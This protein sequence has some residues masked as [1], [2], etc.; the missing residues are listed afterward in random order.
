[1]LYSHALEYRYQNILSCLEGKNCYFPIEIDTEYTHIANLIHP[2]VDY[3]TNIC[4]QCRGINHDKTSIYTYPEIAHISRHKALQTEFVGWDY[5]RDLGLEITPLVLRYEDLNEPVPWIQVD[6]YSFFAVAEFPRVFRGQYREDY[7]NILIHGVRNGGIDQGRRLRTYHREHGYYLNWIQTPWLVLIDNNIYSVRLSIY[8]T[9]ATHGVTN[10]KNFCSNSGIVLPYKDNFT[11]EEKSRMLEMYRDRPDEFDNYAKGDLFN[12]QALIKNADKFSDIYKSLGLERYFTDPKLTIGATVSR[13][14]EAGIYK[15]FDSP[16]VNKNIIN[17]FCKYSSADYI[18]RLSTTGAL[19]A[20][21]DGGRCRNNRPLD[22]NHQGILCDIDISGCY[23]EGL[24]IQEYPLGI[25]TIFDYPR[26]SNPNKYLTLRA[27]LAKYKRY[28]V[29]GLWQARVS[30]K[31]GYLLEHKQD[32]LIS[33]IPPQN[34]SVIPTDT[35]INYTDQWWEIDDIG[36]IKIFNNEIQNAIITHDFLQW[37]DNVATGRQRK[38]LLDNLVVV[39]AMWYSKKDRVNSITELVESHAKH[40]GY[41]T[42]IIDYLNQRQRKVFI[43][44]E[45]HKWYAVNLGELLVDKLLIERKKHPKKTPLNNL[46]KLCINTVYGDMVSPFFK[47]GNV[48]V[49]NNITARARSLAWCM[50]KGLNGW[51]TITDGCTF[52]VNEVAYP[53]QNRKLNGVNTVH[54][55][56]EKVVDH[57]SFKSINICDNKDNYHEDSLVYKLDI[58]NQLVLNQNN[59]EIATIENFSQLISQASIRHLRNSFPKLDILHL[60]SHDVYGNSRKGLFEF[61]VKGLFTK[62]SFHGSANYMLCCGND[63]KIAMRSYSKKPN[64]CIN[65]DTKIDFYDEEI[66]PAQE[67][68][69]SLS[70]NIYS[71]PRSKVFIEE[72]VLKIGDYK[73]NYIKWQDTRVYPGCTVHNAR[74]LREFSLSQFT[75]NNYKQYKSW[76][77]EYESLRRKY[78]QSYEM[79][80]LNEDGT[81]AYQTMVEDVENAIRQGVMKF[82]STKQRKHR[83]A[84]RDFAVHE[85]Q[86]CLDATKAAI[87]RLQKKRDIDKE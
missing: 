4:V 13:I 15:L 75:F 63:M 10:Y 35:E 85:Q 14:F 20:K 52:D 6:C 79:F 50:E 3:C 29:P 42:T 46:Y 21:V 53:H 86:E 80:Y 69:K 71:V 7:E 83:N 12:H 32:Y 66:L 49:G 72:K 9:S 11:S 25:P 2:E 58:E 65:Y 70:E 87:R 28:F 62:G 37:L 64:K 59:K 16:N 67:F 38:E 68:L 39:T 55:Y 17:L 1:M 48:V 77:R 23:G 24:R 34:I 43:Q 19:N 36:E 5:L 81:L 27:F 56:D 30:L 54:L 51:Q 45:C 60:E 82:V 57:I 22:T 40:K 78:G 41:N 47:V 31:E 33:W 44:E 73:N 8:D 18:K 74:L 84:Y 76:L 61:E 26:N